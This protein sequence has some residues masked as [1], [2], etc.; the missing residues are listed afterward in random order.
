MLESTD[1]EVGAGVGG[2]WPVKGVGSPEGRDGVRAGRLNW[3]ETEYPR[4]MQ[5]EGILP[6][7]QSFHPGS[8]SRLSCVFSVKRKKSKVER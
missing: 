1:R 7:A 3:E 4:A 6:K 8:C 2:A 5:M